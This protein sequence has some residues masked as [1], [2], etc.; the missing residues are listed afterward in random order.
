MRK[1]KTKTFKLQKPGKKVN[2]VNVIFV[3]LASS[4]CLG[5]HIFHHERSH[6][7]MRNGI[8]ESVVQMFRKT[9]I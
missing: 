1:G 7:R 6:L 4:D 5:V 3:I 2:K 9:G 8:L